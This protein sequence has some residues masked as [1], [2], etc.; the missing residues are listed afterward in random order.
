MQVRVAIIREEGS[1]GDREMAAAVF[2]AG[3]EPWDITMS[4]LLQGRAT[5]ETFQGALIKSCIAEHL[6]SH[7]YTRRAV[8]N[9]V[10]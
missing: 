2:S 6:R 9:K 1:N 8:T 5:L 3:M 10:L 4:D 7:A